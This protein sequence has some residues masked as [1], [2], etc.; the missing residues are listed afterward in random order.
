VFFVLSLAG[1]F[2]LPEI[3]FYHFT[4][5]AIPFAIFLAYFFIS[6]KKRLWIYEAALWIMVGFIVMSYF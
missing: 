2:F 3:S 6:A 5:L 4:Q 1:F